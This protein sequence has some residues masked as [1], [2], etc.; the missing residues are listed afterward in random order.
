MQA[1]VIDRINDCGLTIDI[2]SDGDCLVTSHPDGYFQITQDFINKLMLKSRPKDHKPIVTPPQ[3]SPAEKIQKPVAV[4]AN[5]LRRR[6][7]GFA[8]DGSETKHWACVFFNDGLPEARY[9]YKGRTF[10]RN[11]VRSDKIGKNGRIA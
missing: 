11:G 2:Y 7:S 3:L 10:A 5:V 6:V 8:V 9:V 4:E 1:Q